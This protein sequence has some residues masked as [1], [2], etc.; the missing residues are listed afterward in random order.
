MEKEVVEGNKQRL[1]DVISRPLTA[2]VVS[3]NNS[4]RIG[5]ISNVDS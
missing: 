5:R 2:G 3:R 1:K 4:C